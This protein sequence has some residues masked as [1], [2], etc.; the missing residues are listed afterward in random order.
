MFVDEG[1]ISRNCP[2]LGL[3]VYY[4]AAWVENLMTNC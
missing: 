2:E 3:S 4:E 1:L